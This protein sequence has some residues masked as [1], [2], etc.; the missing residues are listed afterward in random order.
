M[1]RDIDNEDGTEIMTNEG[2]KLSGRTRRPRRLGRTVTSRTDDGNEA[3]RGRSTENR[4]ACKGKG[5]VK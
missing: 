5:K 1:G 2:R 3:L 4:N